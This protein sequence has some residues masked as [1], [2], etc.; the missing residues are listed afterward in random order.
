LIIMRD[1]HRKIVDGLLE[2]SNLEILAE[3]VGTR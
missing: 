3:I 1:I 2:L